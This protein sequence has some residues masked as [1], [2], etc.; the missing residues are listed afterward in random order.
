M[1]IK[2]IKKHSQQEHTWDITTPSGSFL[3]PNGCVSHNSSV[4]INSTN[5]IEMP[6]SLISTKESKAGSFTQVVP[7][8]EKLKNKYQ[9]M[10]AQPDC[11]GYL[12]TAA[13]L[14]A[15]VDQSISTNTFYSPKH[16]PDRKVPATLIAKN[17]MLAYTWGL[18]TMYY[19]LI[20]KQGSKV[21][22]E[23]PLEHI[24][25]DDEEGCDSC[26]L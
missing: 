6:M 26:K 9:L 8:Y 24:D 23:A 20:D 12:K 18:K 2:S 10:W 25:F 5:G 4:V 11:V 19:S 1:K 14:A 21:V 13:V 16:F 22:D 7:E 17:L 3:L 15:Y